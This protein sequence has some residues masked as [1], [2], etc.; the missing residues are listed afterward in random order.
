VKVRGR[1]LETMKTYILSSRVSSDGNH[2]RA[3]SSSDNQRI[4]NSL[5]S[6]N[7]AAL[8]LTLLLCSFDTT[9]RRNATFE[10]RTRTEIAKQRSIPER[11][12]HTLAPGAEG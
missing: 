12:R 10:K 11:V 4:V 1:V 9:V 5:S 6:T 3:F 7:I 8:C 2:R